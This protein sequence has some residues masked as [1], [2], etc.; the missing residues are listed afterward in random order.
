MTSTAVPCLLAVLLGAAG[1]NTIFGL[2]ATEQEPVDPMPDA[3]PD[4]P[5]PR[6]GLSYLV[7]ATKVPATMPASPERAAIAG[8]PQVKVGPLHGALTEASYFP[9]NGGE[10]EVPPSLF[11]SPWRLAYT[12]PGD[13][14]HEVQWNPAVGAGQLVVPIFGRLARVAAPAGSGYQITL[15][16][17]R[18]FSAGRV[19]TTG[20]WL[21]VFTGA[22][23]FGTPVDVNLATAT[24]RSGPPGAPEMAARDLVLLVDYGGSSCRVITGSAD[25]EARELSTAGLTPVSPTWSAP[26]TQITIGYEEL[27]DL[28]VPTRLAEVLG[29]RSTAQTARRNVYGRTA[30]VEM[31][32]FTELYND[33][34][35]PMMVPLADCPFAAGDTEPFVD[36]LALAG[37]PAV[38][39]SYTANLRQLPGSGTSLLSSIATVTRTPQAVSFD[40]PIPTAPIMLGALD[41]GNVDGQQ[42]PAGGFVEL[43]FGLDRTPATSTLHHVEVRLHRIS[44]SQLVTERVY[45]IAAAT[46]PAVTFD[47][48]IL[49]PGST[50][51]FSLHTFR[52]RPG[53]ATYDFS[54]SSFPQSTATVYTRTFVTP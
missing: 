24:P 41:L 30:S 17:G 20:I 14:T 44:G 7:G 18:S 1:C 19:F 15:N 10:V 23:A 48:T 47:T 26:S 29:T 27:E 22:K 32:A 11:G 52:G 35:A 25:F 42:L 16:P 2:G 4:G 39:L 33:V 37:F 46:R 49:Q 38:V 21:E 54:T 12:P 50:Y 43:S 45:L 36:P 40:V 13:V 53:A 3:P 28:S 51:V 8:D 34:P 5:S 31:P 9:D 6:V